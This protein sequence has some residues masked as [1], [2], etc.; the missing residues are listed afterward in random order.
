MLDFIK[1]N[2]LS[3]TYGYSSGVLYKGLCSR[4]E[5]AYNQICDWA[6]HEIPSLIIAFSFDPLDREAVFYAALA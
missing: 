3:G 1:N 6:I 2:L 4:G 5:G